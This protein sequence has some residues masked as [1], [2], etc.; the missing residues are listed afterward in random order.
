V[1]GGMTATTMAGGATATT[2]A[3]GAASGSSV[4]AMAQGMKVPMK[5][6][7]S[8]KAATGMAIPVGILGL[9]LLVARRKETNRALAIMGIAL[10]AVV[11]AVPALVG[12]CGSASAICNEVLKPTMLLAGGLVIV[13]SVVVLVLGERR[14]EST[15]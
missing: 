14:R 1:A 10:G 5:C 3:G 6:F 4:A 11:M 9:L 8:A 12:T 2:M 15:V 13:L 7:Y